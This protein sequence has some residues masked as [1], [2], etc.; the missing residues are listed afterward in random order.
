MHRSIATINGRPS[1]ENRRRD[2]I[3]WE[4]V[5]WTC[6]VTKYKKR[7]RSDEPKIYYYTILMDL[8]SDNSY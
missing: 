4:F 3:R 7:R 1:S 6:S 5:V 2:G 8:H